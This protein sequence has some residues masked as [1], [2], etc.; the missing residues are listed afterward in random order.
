[1][2]KKLSYAM[3]LAAIA[4]PILIMSGTAA[5]S[6]QGNSGMPPSTKQ[7]QGKMPQH[8]Q[9]MMEMSTMKQEPHHVLAMAYRDSLVNFAKALRRHA[10]EAKTVDPG[11]ARAAVAEMERSFDQMDRH[12]Q[13]HMK[14]MDETMK[15]QT[16]DMMKQMDAHHAAIQEHL[17]ALH[18]EVHTSVPNANTITQNVAEILKDC[19]GMSKMHA[20]TMEHRMV[21]P[22]DHK[23][24]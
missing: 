9:G 5:L 18:K 1:M 8:Q 23:M 12:H 7:S 22:K 20:G 6:E 3:T 10:A 19:N 17:A 14:T 2:I 24:N 11:F 16:A 21:G 13:D 4:A 15:A